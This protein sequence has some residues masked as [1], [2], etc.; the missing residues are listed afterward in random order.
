MNT[1]FIR[2]MTEEDLPGVQALEEACFSDAW[3]ERL[4]RDMLDSEYDWCRVLAY[5]PADGENMPAGG[6]TV[7]ADGENM[8]TDGGSA[9]RGPRL[10]GYVNIR[11]I[12]D[13]AE[14]MRICVAEGF[15]GRG[16]SHRLLEAGLA[17]MKENGAAAASLEVRAGNA[18][19]IRLYESHGFTLCGTRKR[20]YRDPAEDALIYRK[21]TL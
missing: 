11:V 15:R 12:A 3:S 17:D 13:E 19:A 7:P 8:Q 1:F 6:E 10:A 4:L 2:E 18:P 21:E 20:Y 14:L 9:G 5:A 16:L